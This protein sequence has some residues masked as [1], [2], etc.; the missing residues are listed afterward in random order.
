[1]NIFQKRQ[2]KKQIMENINQAETVAQRAYGCL[3]PANNIYWCNYLNLPRTIEDNNNLSNLYTTLPA[4]RNDIKK[5]AEIYQIN[6][7]LC[8]EYGCEELTKFSENFFKKHF[9]EIVNSI[10]NRINEIKKLPNY[11]ICEEL[12]QT[13]NLLDLTLSKILKSLNFLQIQ[14][15]VEV[16]I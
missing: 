13:V 12:K 7:K 8:C 16:S 3:I 6:E 4:L 5:L 2:I 14:N 9:K 15:Q 1:M 11:N 10:K